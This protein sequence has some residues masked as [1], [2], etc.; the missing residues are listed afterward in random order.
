MV[1]GDEAKEW[2]VMGYERV[3]ALDCLLYAMPR[4]NCQFLI[5]QQLFFSSSSSLFFCFVLYV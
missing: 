2:K 4:S 1:L 3:Y 5:M